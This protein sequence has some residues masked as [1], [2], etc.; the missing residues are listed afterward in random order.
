MSC[1]THRVDISDQGRKRFT[2]GFI[3]AVADL[4]DVTNE[5]DEAKRREF[6]DF[7]NEFGTHYSSVTLLGAKMARYLRFEYSAQE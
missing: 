7:V 2:R 5:D 4:N 1:L 6:I 3:D